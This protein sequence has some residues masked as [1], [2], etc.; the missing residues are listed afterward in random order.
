MIYIFQ[1]LLL[2]H[3]IFTV[4]NILFRGWNFI[5]LLNKPYISQLSKTFQRDVFTDILLVFLIMSLETDYTHEKY[6]IYIFLFYS[7]S[8]YFSKTIYF[9]EVPF[10]TAATRFIKNPQ[11]FIINDPV[12]T[13]KEKKEKGQVE[14]N[15]ENVEV[16]KVG[17]RW[18]WG[19]R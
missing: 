9:R 14:G 10:K 2:S 13:H 12:A 19:S 17:G 4:I 7:T 1:I 5:P 8:S 18:L 6:Y 15:V 3:F 16:C 11:K